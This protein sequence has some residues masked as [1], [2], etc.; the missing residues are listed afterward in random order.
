MVDLTS[1]RLLL[2]AMMAA[3]EKSEVARGL[4]S[5]GE[6]GMLAGDISLSA[7]L[8][9]S[10]CL[11]VSHRA[12]ARRTRTSRRRLSHDWPRYRSLLPDAPSPGGRSLLGGVNGTEPQP[13]PWQRGGVSATDS[14]SPPVLVGRG[15]ASPTA[16]RCRSVS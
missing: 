7:S 9:V 10:G 8:R 1:A 3:M 5:S 12:A 6:L 14:Q 13:S 2:R 16:G 15:G 11:R 4:A